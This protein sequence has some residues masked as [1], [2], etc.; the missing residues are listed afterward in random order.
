MCMVQK[1]KSEYEAERLESGRRTAEAAGEVALLSARLVE[2]ER[3]KTDLTHALEASQECNRAM[4]LESATLS[5]EVTALQARLADFSE[6]LCAQCHL[7]E[8]CERCLTCKCQRDPYWSSD[9]D[10]E[11]RIPTPRT[12]PRIKY[13]EPPPPS[14]PGK[15]RWM[16]I[17]RG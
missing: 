15:R 14:R 3:D 2:R 1:F 16:P 6:A 13:V 12:V 10:E 5:D 7:A 9:D 8:R 4:R 11:E 17:S